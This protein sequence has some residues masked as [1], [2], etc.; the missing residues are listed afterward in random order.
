MD[1]R[2]IFEI[3]E[4]TQTHIHI[5]NHSLSRQWIFEGSS[6]K[7]QKMRRSER[8]SKEEREDAPKR[9]KIKEER[10][11]S[12]SKRVGLELPL[13]AVWLALWE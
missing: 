12:S 8:A 2:D 9:A 11:K 13:L 5:L 7:D 1:V 6:M 3:G 10:R 4:H